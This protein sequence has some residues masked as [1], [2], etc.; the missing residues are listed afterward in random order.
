MI[1]QPNKNYIQQLSAG[2]PEF[3]KKIVGII[4][5]EFP[6]EKKEFLNNFNNKQFLKTAENVHKLKHKIG[7]LG[8]EIGY[9][10]AID[11]EEGL[12]ENN[13]SLFPKFIVI[14]DSIETFLDTL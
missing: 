4:Q 9:Q 6:E 5:R 3:E 11:F 2:D 8:F 1:E 12:K 10:T 7:M 13:P 14:L